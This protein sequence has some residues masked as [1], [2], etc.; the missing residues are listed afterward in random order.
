[1][2]DPRYFVI[3]MDG[4]VLLK[5]RCDGTKSSL[6]ACLSQIELN[7]NISRFFCLCQRDSNVYWLYIPVICKRCALITRWFRDKHRDH[8]QPWIA[9]GDLYAPKR[10]F[11]DQVAPE[12]AKKA[13]PYFS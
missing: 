13:D 7:L 2:P 12:T 9:I 5:S 6:G 11:S 4:I 8:S 1:M 10:L 3:L